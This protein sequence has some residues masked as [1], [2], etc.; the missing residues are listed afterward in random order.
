MNAWVGVKPKTTREV[1]G[2]APNC[3]WVNFSVLDCSFRNPVVTPGSTAKANLIFIWVCWH[4]NNFWLAS[5][6]FFPYHITQKKKWNRDWTR[7]LL[8]RSW[9]LW[10]LDH[11]SLSNRASRSQMVFFASKKL[12]NFILNVF[13]SF[14]FRRDV[15]GTRED[16]RR[17][18][19][20]GEHPLWKKN[21]FVLLPTRWL[22]LIWLS[23]AASA[24]H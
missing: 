11:G 12:L 1:L 18:R 15:D 21:R 14:Y 4:Q 16:G 7:I 8:L 22:N 2:Y 20:A 23:T 10:P 5:S 9:P 13:F 24:S 6:Q 3:H 19:L 17:V